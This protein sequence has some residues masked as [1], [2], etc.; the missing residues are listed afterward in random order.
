MVILLLKAGIDM[1]AATI[2]KHTALHTAATHGRKDVVQFL[3]EKGADVTA[4]D[5]Y[6]N[7]PFDLAVAGG[8]EGVMEVLSAR[9]ALTEK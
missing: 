3:L 8:H 9:M 7:T 2:N 1:S 5:I 4:A 6:N